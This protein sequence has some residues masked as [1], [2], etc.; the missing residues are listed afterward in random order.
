MRG[1][2]GSN[3]VINGQ[4]KSANFILT[5]EISFNPSVFLFF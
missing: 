5:T 3:N 1:G 2:R 4:P